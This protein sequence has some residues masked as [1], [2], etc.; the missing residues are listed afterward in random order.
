MSDKK[1]LNDF[2]S[3]R[4]GLNRDFE[5]G[6]DFFFLL[7]VMHLMVKL[8]IRFDQV[9]FYGLGG[10]FDYQP[11]RNFLR[12]VPLFTMDSLAF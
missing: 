9:D 7:L 5:S 10:V 12:Q 4:K 3:E 8:E 11:G 1:V 6:V 2:L